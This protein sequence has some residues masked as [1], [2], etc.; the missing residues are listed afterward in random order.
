MAF[1]K[2]QLWP[3]VWGHTRPLLPEP[4][5]AT[6]FR[7]NTVHP[8]PSGPSLTGLLEPAGTH[9]WLHL[10]SAP[11]SVGGNNPPLDRNKKSP[12]EQSGAG[13]WC[14]QWPTTPWD[15]VFAPYPT[16]RTLVPCGIHPGPSQ[17]P[18]KAWDLQDVC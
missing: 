1:Q 15:T 8:S 14:R 12:G 9:I 2:L 17:G 10:A 11:T 4:R 13:Q 5:L 6:F 18:D 16:Q 3:T 7:G